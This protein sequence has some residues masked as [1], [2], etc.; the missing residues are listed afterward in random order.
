MRICVDARCLNRLHVRGIGRLLT[1][2]IERSPPAYSWI[3]LAD[4]D[5]LPFHRPKHANLQVVILGERGYRYHTWTQLTLPLAATWFRGDLLLCPA[6]EAP[7]LSKIPTV[8]IVH[9]VIEWKPEFAGEYKKSPYRDRLLPRAFSQAAKLITVS[10]TSATEIQQLWPACSP[11]VIYNGVS[12][13]FFLAREVRDGGTKGSVNSP[14]PYVLYIGGEIPRKRFDWALHAWEPFA[15]RVEL[16]I[17]GM[18]PDKGK[19]RI[20]RL[21]RRSRN[22]ITFLKFVPDKK[23][24][25]VMGA[26][27]CILYPT[28]YEGFGLPVI[29]ANAVGTR[30]IYSPRGSLAEL[31][32]PLSV[33]LPVADEA[34]W[35]RAIGDAIKAPPTESER[36]AARTWARQFD[37]NRTAAAYQSIFHSVVHG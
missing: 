24:P 21:E 29:E 13:S 35:S 16:R 31:T 27:A 22:Q 25:D 1:E 32:G 10:H 7:L 26:A 23:L 11:A 17:L 9:D 33:S 5:E 15:D 34:A 28:L 2:V 37:W 3:L 19:K 14:A 18:D 36:R 6:N 30:I 4:R 12:D 8:S 20:E